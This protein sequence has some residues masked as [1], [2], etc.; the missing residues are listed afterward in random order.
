MTV[1]HPTEA[2]HDAY[3]LDLFADLAAGRN[4]ALEGLWDHCADQLYGFA[5]WRT[6]SVPDAEDVVQEVWVRLAR[7]GSRLAAVRNPRAYLL[8]MAHNCAADLLSRRRTVPLDDSV[9]TVVE[10]VEVDDADARIDG[11]RASALVLQLSPKLREVI[12][13]HQL[14]GLSFREIAGVC[15]VPLFTAASRH[16]LAIRRLRELMGVEN[17]QRP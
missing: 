12:F 14:A 10:V 16:R 13:L 4:E 11:R 17:D 15:G 8:R 9:S 2:T 1:D 3:L 5:L 6:G 7:S